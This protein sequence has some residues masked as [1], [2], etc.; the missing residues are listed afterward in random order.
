MALMFHTALVGAVVFVIL[1]LVLPHE[2]LPGAL[3]LGLMAV[4]G[5]LATAG[6]LLFTAA[7]REAPAAILAPVNYMHIAFAT[8]LGWLVF[9][10]VPDA[11]G[12]AGM[13][14]IAAAGIIAAWQAIRR[15]TV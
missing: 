3:D 11:I 4:L 7:Y 15:G 13:G 14:A 6:H 10:Q 12:F 8:L 9:A 5:A 2:V 1:A